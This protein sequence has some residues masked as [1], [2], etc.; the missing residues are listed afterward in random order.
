MVIGDVAAPS[1]ELNVLI[2]DLADVDPEEVI[3]AAE[4]P[5][6]TEPRPYGPRDRR[7]QARW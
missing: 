6:Q 4:E 1:G 5:E 3:A 7:G 2:S